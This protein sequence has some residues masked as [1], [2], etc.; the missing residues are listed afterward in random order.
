MVSVIHRGRC[1]L[2]LSKSAKI[3]R[4][5]GRVPLVICD[6][7]HRSFSELKTEQI[8]AIPGQAFCLGLSAT[9]SF[10]KENA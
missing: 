4:Q 10:S 7:F 1:N 2:Y 3:I 5:W 8:E 6:E 9:P